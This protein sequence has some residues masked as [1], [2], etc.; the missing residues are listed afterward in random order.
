MPHGTWGH[1]SPSQASE[2]T[3]SKSSGS[4]VVCSSQKLGADPAV[5]FSSGCHSVVCRKNLSRSM[6]LPEVFRDPFDWIQVHTAHHVYHRC[7][8]HVY[9]IE[10]HLAVVFE[11]AE[12]R[13]PLSR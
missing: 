9:H 10:V 7:I 6:D 2:S 8:I 1:S 4:F 12:G 13:K 11:R 5:L 3:V